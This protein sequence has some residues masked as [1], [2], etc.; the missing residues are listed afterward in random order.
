MHGTSIWSL[1]SGPGL[2]KTIFDTILAFA[3]WLITWFWCKGQVTWVNPTDGVPVTP[4]GDTVP[5]TPVGDTDGVPVIP[6]GDTVDGVPVPFVVYLL[7]KWN[8][9]VRNFIKFQWKTSE[10]WRFFLFKEVL[11]R[12][13]SL[14]IHKSDERTALVPFFHAWMGILVHILRRRFM[15]TD[16]GN[17]RLSG[18]WKQGESFI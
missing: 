13:V 12:T 6:V 1:R 5:V 2:I 11:G 14:I 16:K 10:T 3:L 18:E 9:T 4:V 17:T 15:M 7:K 8:Q